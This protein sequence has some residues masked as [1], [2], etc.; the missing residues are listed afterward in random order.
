M[1]AFLGEWVAVKDNTDWT[2]FLRA[3]GMD[4]EKIEYY[5]KL[6]Q[7]N[8]TIVSLTKDGDGFFFKSDCGPIKFSNKFQLGKPYDVTMDEMSFKGVFKLE[9]GVLKDESMFAGSKTSNPSEKTVTTRTISG[10]KMITVSTTAGIS[11]TRT[12]K[13]K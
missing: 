9:D 13:K 3:S 12:F 11:L 1:E 8:E 5:K 10:D 2:P 6:D 7:E 4:D